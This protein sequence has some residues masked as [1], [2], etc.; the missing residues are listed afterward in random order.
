MGLNGR[1]KNKLKELGCT[2]S[3]LEA[4]RQAIHFNKTNS[5]CAPFLFLYLPSSSFLF[6]PVS[7]FMSLPFFLYLP[8]PSFVSLPSFLF[9]LPSSSFNCLHLP[10]F[11]LFFLYV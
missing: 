5:R 3:H 11:N 10:S 8:L 9:S 1:Q 7:S 6:L 4:M 2:A